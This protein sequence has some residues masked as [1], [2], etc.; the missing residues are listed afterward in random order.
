MLLDDE[1]HYL[2]NTATPQI[3]TLK[4]GHYPDGAPLVNGGD[5][6]G[7]TRICVRPRSI[8]TLVATL[9]WVDAL[10][11]RGHAVPELVLPCL[12]GA[13]QDRLNP[14]GDYLFTAKSIA[15]MINERK[16]PKVITVDPHSEVMP[17]LIER[18]SVIR[19]RDIFF[20][21]TQ[22]FT[23][24][25]VV[26]PDAG[27]AKRSA[28][29]AHVLDV[30]VIQAW[31]KRDIATGSLSDFGIER[32]EPKGRKRALVVDDLCDGG[33]TFVGLAPLIDI[34]LN[35]EPD[36]YVTHG[37]FTKGLGELLQHYSNIYTTDSVI[38]DAVGRFV[39]IGICQ[40]L[41]ERGYLV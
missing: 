25:Y 41:L 16:F 37:L 6:G 20:W 40:T 30:P 1:V 4:I 13:R 39:R 35:Q 3:R 38:S 24:S 15:K 31:K 8:E 9:F 18:C 7:I 12:P 23:W 2:V 33:G 14:G 19:A 27:A 21:Q 29:V 11:E 28:E 17:A 36:L 26:A 5:F 32:I 10:V 22:P 34:G